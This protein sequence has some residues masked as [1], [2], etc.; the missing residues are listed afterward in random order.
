M[1]PVDRFV[2][3]LRVVAERQTFARVLRDVGT[4]ALLRSILAG[5]YDSFNG[6]SSKGIAVQRQK[7]VQ[8]CRELSQLM[9][10]VPDA[11]I[12]C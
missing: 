4:P 1:N 9:E 12:S 7:R 8:I 2:L 3:M 10:S 6:T 5:R 11:Y